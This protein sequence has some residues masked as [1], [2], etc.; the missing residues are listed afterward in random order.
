MMNKQ[1]K[2]N[3]KARLRELRDEDNSIPKYDRKIEWKEK[4]TS[5]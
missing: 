4:G 2:K 1:I 5:A 3:E